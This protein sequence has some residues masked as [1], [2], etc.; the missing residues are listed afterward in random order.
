MHL[1]ERR[2]AHLSTGER[3]RV[4]LARALV[5]KPD[6]LLL[7]EPTSHLDEQGATWVVEEIERLSNSGTSVVFSNHADDRLSSIA[8][9]Q[10]HL[11]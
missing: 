5:R 7:D 2:P 1:A 8:T 6:L 9:H 10:L 11:S 4:D 3:R